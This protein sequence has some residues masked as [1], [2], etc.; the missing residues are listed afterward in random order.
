MVAECV[1]RSFCPEGRSG[2]NWGPHTA[3]CAGQRG[4]GGS[5]GD[6]FLPGTWLASAH[7]PSLWRIP[8]GQGRAAPPGGPSRRHSTSRSAT[9]NYTARL[10]R[11]FKQNIIDLQNYKGRRQ[12]PSSLPRLIF[13]RLWKQSLP[14]FVHPGAR[15]LARLR[16]PVLGDRSHAEKRIPA[17]S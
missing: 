16:W 7:R 5:G 1:H 12:L 2:G 15:E 4:V 13:H 6:G 11:T 10:D 14:G 8:G 9:R 17:P 3:H